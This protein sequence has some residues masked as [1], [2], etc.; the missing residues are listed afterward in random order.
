V[1]GT[2]LRPGGQSTGDRYRALE[3]A[4]PILGA[5]EWRQGSLPRPRSS[6]A[7]TSWRR[8]AVDRLGGGS[9]HVL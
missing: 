2:T 6:A 8:C 9:G 5:G 7:P 1:Q 4:L 3:P